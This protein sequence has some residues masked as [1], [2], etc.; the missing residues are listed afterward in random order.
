ME[1][2]FTDG[3]RAGILTQR[4]LR[5]VKVSDTLRVPTSRAQ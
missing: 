3:R 2:G 4:T 1:N 5:V